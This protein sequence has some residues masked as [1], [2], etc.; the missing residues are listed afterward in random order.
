[1]IAKT[2]ASIAENILQN[3][4][5][6]GPLLKPLSK[7]NIHCTW[8][9]PSHSSLEV[10]FD[11]IMTLKMPVAMHNN[12][13]TRSN[14]QQTNRLT[15]HYG[16]KNVGRY[17]QGWFMFHT[18]NYIFNLFSVNIKLYFCTFFQATLAEIKG[19]LS[20]KP[21]EREMYIP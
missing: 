11:F 13:Y 10:N 12:N 19:D 6:F 14:C 1:M 15:L 8:K 21:S 2:I 7:R 20:F 5:F 18:L 3:R 9:T 17:L 4:K 16:I